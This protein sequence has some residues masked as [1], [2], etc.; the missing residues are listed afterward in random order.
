MVDWSKVSTGVAAVAVAAAFIAPGVMNNND[1]PEVEVTQ[2]AIDEAVKNAV[3]GAMVN[4]N[5]TLV[6]ILDGVDYSNNEE[7]LDDAWEAKA[8]L[9]AEDEFTERDFKDI[10]NAM[11]DNNISI[12]DKDDIDRVEIKDV[13]VTGLDTDDK[14]ATVVHELKVYYEN[15]Q[16]DDKKQNMIVTTTLVDGY[17]D[18]QLI[19]LD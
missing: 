5:G 17:V 9:I 7:V 3:D 8:E 14:D 10:F 6:K 11:T 1:A 19:E 12:D 4:I 15:A 16:G 2:E 13:D 18:E